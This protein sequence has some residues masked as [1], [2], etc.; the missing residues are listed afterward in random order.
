VVVAIAGVVAAVSAFGLSHDPSD[1]RPVLV[2]KQAPLFRATTLDGSGAIRLEAL[3]GQV[4]VLNFWSSWCSACLLEHPSLTRAWTR[5]RDRGVVFV[6]MDF[7]DAHAAATSFARRLGIDY[8]VVADP[9]DRT[10]L[11]FGVSAPPETFLIG[12]DGRI[13]SKWT[14]PVPYGELSS[15]I[16]RLLE[17]GR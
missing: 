10:A 2:G 12:A 11:A 8:P 9:G 15:Q 4:V 6:G 3:R 14:G 17:T 16:E 1:V 13:E 5:F 7:N